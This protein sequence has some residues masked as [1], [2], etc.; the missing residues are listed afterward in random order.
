MSILVIIE[1]TKK[2][3][4][5]ISY[6]VLAAGQALGKD[7]DLPVSALILGYKTAR[8][9]ELL[10]GIQLN[11]ILVAEH[12]L[13]INYSSDGFSDAIREVVKQETPKFILAGHTYMAR[14]FL[15]RVSAK[16][17]FPFLADN[18]SYRI[19]KNHSLILRKQIFSGKLSADI[20][21]NCDKPVIISFQSSAFK[22][23]DIIEGRHSAIR[24]ISLSM[25][26]DTIRSIS[27]P[28]F[29]EVTGDI[30]LS[31]ADI[32]VSIGRGIGSEN[33]V[34][35]AKDLAKIM[36]AKLAS[37]RPVV[38][39]GW[40]E[41]YHQIGSSG[42]TVAPKL[43]FALGISGA[44][45]HVVGIKGSKNIILINKDAEAPLFEFAD[46]GIVGDILEIIP[47]LIKALRE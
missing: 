19:E 40:L 47:K 12:P 32:I 42:K 3:P 7:F 8:I 37:S 31:N 5:Q 28:P 15:P 20:I 39:A 18:I 43:Y 34:Q 41:P 4:H 35:I 23:E 9:V 45:Q 24:K 17:N 36:G 11:E 22:K 1:Q 13:L 25:D 26:P 29:Q 14:D 6:E 44:I 2:G 21:P 10:K 38:D 46:Y 30:D 33:N 27:E 16:L